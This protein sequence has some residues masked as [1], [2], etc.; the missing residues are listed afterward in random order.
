M[1]QSDPRLIKK[2]SDNPASSYPVSL[3]SAQKIALKIYFSLVLAISIGGLFFL[4][5]P[6]AIK[7]LTIADV[8]V[9]I[10]MSFLQDETARNAYFTGDGQKLHDRLNQ[11]G[12]EEQIKDFYRPQIPDEIA[13]DLY[14]HQLLYDRT[15]YVGKAYQL[16]AQGV[17]V[18]KHNG[19]L[20]LPP[21]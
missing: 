5:N 18:L 8:P 9:S 17:L 2:P 16:N 3:N 15:G 4:R 14:I 7:R 19:S 13:L 11:M 20:N 12:V 1:A 10:V 21:Y 6:D